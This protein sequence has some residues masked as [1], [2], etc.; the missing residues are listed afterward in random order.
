M[1]LIPDSPELLGHFGLALYVLHGS[2]EGI[3]LARRAAVVDPLNVVAYGL[4]G[5]TLRL[6]GRRSEATDYFSKAL[7][8]SPNASQ[9]HSMISLLL[10]EEGR[11]AEAA[12][13]AELEVTPWSREFTRAVVHGAAGN[14]EASDRG[15]AA[16]IKSNGDTALYQIALAHAARGEVDEAFAALDRGYALRDPGLSLS[17]PEPLLR[18]LHDDPR[19]PAFLTRMGFAP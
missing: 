8:L 6:A 15:L 2:E 7:E 17:R 3:E 11:H 1:E 14:R 16:L 18:N 19:W 9:C 13:D 10:S 5:R 4:A 12:A